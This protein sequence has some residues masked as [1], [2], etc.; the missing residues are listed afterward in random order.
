MNSSALKDRIKAIAAEK[1]VTFNEVWKQILLERFLARLSSSDHHQKFI[2]KGG[3]LLAQYLVIGRE[4]TDADFLL[5][6]LKSETATI[7]TAFKEIVAGEMDDGFTFSW[8]STEELKQPHM[9]YPGFRVSLAV[10]FEK[11]KDKIQIDIGVGD[12]VEPIED[13]F[14]PFEYKGKPIFSGEISLL[15][16]PVETIFAEKLETI[17]SKGVNNS[18]MKDYHDVILMIREPALIDA[19]KLNVAVA[20]TFQNRGTTL[21]IPIEFDKEGSASLQKLWASHLNGLGA[22]KNKLRLPDQMADVLAEANVWLAHNL[23]DK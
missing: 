5:R 18:R 22:F 20:G 13:N 12:L 10:N 4:T 1:G 15:M 14:H 3:L 8:S 2:F 21:R 9:D 6:K 17:T 23:R 16:Y 11:M 19:K 7:E